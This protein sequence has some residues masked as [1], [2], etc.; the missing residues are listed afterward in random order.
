MWRERE[1]P[2]N[3]SNLL[4]RGSSLK[5]TRWA[6]GVVVYTGKDTKVMMNSPKAPFYLTLNLFLI[7]S[8]IF[9]LILSRR[10]R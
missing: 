10:W 4:L 3:A 7:L 6:L 2:L 9:T 5:N 8:L 1:V